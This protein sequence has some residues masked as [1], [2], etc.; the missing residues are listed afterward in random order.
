[1]ECTP[2][3]TESQSKTDW[4]NL[5]YSKLFAIILIHTAQRGYDLGVFQVAPRFGH[6]QTF[7]SSPVL[8][9]MFILSQD[10]VKWE[11]WDLE[12][13]ADQP[14]GEL[15]TLISQEMVTIWNY[16]M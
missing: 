3:D 16:Y 10:Q 14:S 5:V 2:P 9:V 13:T 6:L 7:S 12:S 11:N 4:W 1:M 15:L 8:W